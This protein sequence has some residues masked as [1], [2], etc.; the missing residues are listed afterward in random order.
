[1]EREKWLARAGEPGEADMLDLRGD[2]L[3]G[4]TIGYRCAKPSH[5]AAPSRAGRGGLTVQRREWAYCD[6][7][8]VDEDHE[9][10]ATGG[11][12]IEQ[13]INWG[14]ATISLAI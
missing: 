3:S 14:Q 6:G 7:L 4:P 12:E 9:W 10:E 1:M 2:V 11:V 5:L 13:L 8:D